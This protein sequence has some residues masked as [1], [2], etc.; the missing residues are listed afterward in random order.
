MPFM[1]GQEWWLTPVIPALWEAMVGELP[2]IRSSR[3]AWPTWQNP[4]STKN[5]QIS[6]ACSYMPVIPAT[7]GAE[8]GGSLE[9]GRQRLLRAQIVPLHPSLGDRVRLLLKKKKKKEKKKKRKLLHIL[10]FPIRYRQS[11]P[12]SVLYLNKLPHLF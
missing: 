6:Q 10:F 1:A 11:Q 8:A 12:F 4:I 3:P 5:I 7:S 9:P 2:E